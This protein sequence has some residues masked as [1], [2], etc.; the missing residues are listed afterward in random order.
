MSHPCLLM[1]PSVEIGLNNTSTLPWCGVLCFAK[2][3][4]DH[5]PVSSLGAREASQQVAPALSSREGPLCCCFLP[6]RVLEWADLVS[7]PNCHLFPVWPPGYHLTWVCFFI[8]QN[9]LNAL[10]YHKAFLTH[11]FPNTSQWVKG[12]SGKREAVGMDDCPVHFSSELGA[13]TLQPLLL[14]ISL[15]IKP[16]STGLLR[17]SWSVVIHILTLFR[18]CSNLKT[19]P[20]LCRWQKELKKYRQL[21]EGQ[22]KATV[23]ASCINW[24]RVNSW[25]SLKFLLQSFYSH[26]IEMWCR[27]TLTKWRQQRWSSKCTKVSNRGSGW[28]WG[29]G[30]IHPVCPVWPGVLTW[31]EPVL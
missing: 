31:L 16:F 26:L 25:T 5:C 7:N 19:D 29:H 23:F 6:P 3:F 9:V 28:H 2:G 8:R 14:T 30:W 22:R 27:W 12:E 18:N 11:G 13:L 10:T 24:K 20:L 21:Q 4:Y 1:M 17:I 15:S